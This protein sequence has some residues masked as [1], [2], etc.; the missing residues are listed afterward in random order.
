[1]HFRINKPPVPPWVLECA[2]RFVTIQIG[3]LKC[4][5]SDIKLSYFYENEH[6]GI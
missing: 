6:T 1:M 4:Q 5:Q 3:L 2:M